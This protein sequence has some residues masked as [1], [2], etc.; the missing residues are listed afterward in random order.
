MNK[1][2]TMVFILMVSISCKT[3]TKQDQVKE[4]VFEKRSDLQLILDSAQ[5]DGAILIYDQEKDTYY[6]NNFE[7]SKKGFLPASTFK[8]PNSI[9]ALETG[10][11]KNDSTLMKWDGIERNFKIWNQDLIFKKAFQYSCVPCYQEVA[12]K[13]GVDQM[14]SYLKKLKYDGMVFDSASID[15]FWL[16]GASSISPF[17]EID[18]LKRLYGSKLPIQKRTE[19]IIKKMM[20]I[21]T[22]DQYKLSGKTGWASNGDDNN[23]WFV[24]FLELSDNT[25]FFATNIEPTESF[26]MKN[27]P[28]ARKAVTMKVL[29]TLNYL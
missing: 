1:L 11:V 26:D 21:E 27:F 13:I 22:K 7:W 19:A 18:F 12:R 6:S 24:G 20:L 2:I 14:K 10:V 29:N 8:I 3:K 23:G 17:S 16:V 9:I 4:T 15:T 25:I 28:K 5:L